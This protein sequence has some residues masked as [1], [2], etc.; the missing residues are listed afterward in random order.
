MIAANSNQAVQVFHD[1]NEYGILVDS[2][3][4]LLN[5]PPAPLIMSMATP[6]TRKDRKGDCDASLQ[7]ILDDASVLFK[8][9]MTTEDAYPDI[10]K[11]RMWAK[12]ALTQAAI[13]HG[14]VLSPDASI[15]RL[16]CSCPAPPFGLL[17]PTIFV[18]GFSLLLAPPQ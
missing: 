16:V 8:C 2:E 14:V 12:A 18:A 7:E 4:T 17:M 11:A 1:E 10:L 5:M 9:R 15:T 3:T 13:Q 6:S